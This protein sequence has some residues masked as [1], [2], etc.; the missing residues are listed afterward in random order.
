VALATALTAATAGAA[1]Q[2]SQQADLLIKFKNVETLK[3]FALMSKGSGSK[4]ETLGNSNWVHVNLSPAQQKQISI[5]DIRSNPEVLAVQPN[6]KLHLLENYQLKSPALRA[7]LAKL[8]ASSNFTPQAM[9]ADNPPFP[10][11]GSGGTGADPDFAK[12]WGMNDIGLKKGLTAHRGEGVVVAVIDTGVDYTH[13]DLVDNMWHN[14][15]E[16]GTD[17]QGRDKASNGI[18]DDGNGYIDDVMGWDFASN[19]NKP[20]DLAVDPIQILMGGGNP[21]HGTHCA[22]NVAA[23][24]DN[25]KGVEG[26]APNA[27]IMALRFLS[28]KGEGDT[29][30]AIKAIDYAVAN[31]AQVLSNS[32]GSEGDDPAEAD[33]NQALKDA[34]QRANDKGVIFIA[35]AGNGHQGVGYDN[36]SDAKPGVPASYD[37]ENIVSVAALDVNNNLGPFSNW[38]ARTVDIGAP[39]VAVYSTTVGSHYSDTVIDMY[40]I[41]A[42]WDG[43][44]MAC[45]HVAGAAALYLSAHPGATVKEIKDALINSATPLPNLAGKTVS[46]GKLNVE[47]LMQ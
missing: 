35:A 20:F 36:D 5:E 7:Q 10:T 1:T 22:G 21:G 23:R 17:A 24:G 12:Q 32:W 42:T 40:G 43:T 8:V 34:I 26:V 18:D 2:T 6:Y 4:V 27:Q 47:K 31:G 46:G 3:A 15:G 39:G 13:E 44:S 19:D 16:M 38:G 37:N 14:K 29:A 45:P 41:K 25:G 30:G 33:K 11:S 28:E 9:P